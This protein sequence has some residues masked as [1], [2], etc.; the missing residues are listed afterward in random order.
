MVYGVDTFILLLLRSVFI[1]FIFVYCGFVF[2]YIVNIF[3]A[4]QAYFKWFRFFCS[5]EKTTYGR[6]R[7][8]T[9]PPTSVHE[10]AAGSSS[11]CGVVT[12]AGTTAAGGAS[13]T[14][15]PRDAEGGGGG[16]PF[17][18]DI[19]TQKG[20]S[21][22]ETR[23]QI[24]SSGS[25][26]GGGGGGGGA[27]AAARRANL[28]P[29]SGTGS[30]QRLSGGGGNR[31]HSVT[32][33]ALIDDENVSALQQVCDIYIYIY[34]F[35]WNGVFDEISVCVQVTRGGGALTLASQWKSQFDDSEETT[36]NEWKQEPQVRASSGVDLQ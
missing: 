15:S 30:T 21:S 13:E 9:A 32:Q 4:K 24:V 19:N 8:L 26:S 5:Q 33:F 31:D 36:D 28:R 34:M 20:T 1:L 27:G 23:R 12:V 11:V 35:Q 3:D 22:A 2:V 7:V 16:S 18:F 25:N 14:A 29:S 6:L 10:L 17:S